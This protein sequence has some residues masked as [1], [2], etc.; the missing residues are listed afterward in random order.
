MTPTLVVRLIFSGLVL[1][2]SDE[3]PE[4]RHFA[5][6]VDDG[7]HHHSTLLLAEGSCVGCEPSRLE[8]PIRELWDLENGPWILSFPGIEVSTSSRARDLDPPQTVDLGHFPQ[9]AIQARDTYWIPSLTELAGPEARLDPD[10][11]AGDPSSCGTGLAARVVIPAGEITSCH[12]A[13]E[14]M[15]PA[16]ARVSLDACSEFAAP[17]LP[18]PLL[19][20]VF[21]P[22]EHCG[23]L[24]RAIAGAFMVELQI[25]G[26]PR[27]GGLLMERRLYGSADPGDR[28]ELRGA[29]IAPDVRRLTLVVLNE[30][31]G[32]AEQDIRLA[33]E[34]QPPLA[35]NLVAHTHFRAFY[36]MLDLPVGVTPG[37]LPIP[38]TF[39]GPRRVWADAGTCEPYLECL[40]RRPS[41]FVRTSGNPRARLTSMPH[42]SA[43]C[44][45]ASYP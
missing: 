1:L 14:S 45:V 33:A 41:S 13:H 18:V 11:L 34:V 7:A 5:L 26:D 40:S 25:P 10:C 9:D 38:Y 20:A 29:W 27:G 22:C 28:L 44:D 23:P 8:V 17:P 32:T 30:P 37:D 35:S 16:V 12:L 4:G 43:L 24:P 39:P 6:L 3:A 42:S 19:T 36:D 15:Q 31:P 21:D 2:A